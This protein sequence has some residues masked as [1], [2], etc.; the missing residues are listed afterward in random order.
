[1][2]D[3]D[4]QALIVVVVVVFVVVAIFILVPVLKE[5]VEGLLTLETLLP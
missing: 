4:G 3:E 2:R 5:A 1:M